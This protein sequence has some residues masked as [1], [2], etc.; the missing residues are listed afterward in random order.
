MRGIL[1]KKCNGKKVKALLAFI[2]SLLSTLPKLASAR[3]N[4][5]C[6][7]GVRVITER[8]AVPPAACSA[9]TTPK[10]ESISTTYYGKKGYRIINLINVFLNLNHYMVSTFSAYL[11]PTPVRL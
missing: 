5:C 9:L 4:I 11:K 6:G 3:Q 8:R 7:T 2:C 10:K 1:C